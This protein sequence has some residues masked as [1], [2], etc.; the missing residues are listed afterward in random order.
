LIRR[1]KAAVFRWLALLSVVP[2]GCI[3]L[4]LLRDE[5]SLERLAAYDAV[6][7]QLNQ[8]YPILMMTAAFLVYVAA[9]GASVPGAAAMAVACGWLFGFRTALILVSL[10]STSG[11]SLAFL[12][13]RVLLRRAVRERF[14]QPLKDIESVLQRDGAFYL[15]LLRLIPIIPFFVINIVMGLTPIRL[16]T[17][18]WVSQLGMLPATILFVAAGA[19]VPTLDSLV[20]QG[21]TGILTLKVM[22]FFTALGLLPLMA[23]WMFVQRR[24]MKSDKTTAD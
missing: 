14:E 24:A 10:A 7:R 15:F 13:S 6:V 1:Q 18:W 16:R 5:F 17:F 22:A 4:Y 8:D 2:A 3:A 12:T 19:T 20:N 23:R 11:A 9:T 21:I